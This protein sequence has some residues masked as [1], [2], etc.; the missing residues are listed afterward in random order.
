[1]ILTSKLFELQLLLFVFL[2]FSLFDYSP[3][4]SMLLLHLINLWMEFAKLDPCP[5]SFPCSS[6][7]KMSSK[8]KRGST[9]LGL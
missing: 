8:M 1:M 6:I 2:G 3:S 9:S 4:D 7:K 5:L